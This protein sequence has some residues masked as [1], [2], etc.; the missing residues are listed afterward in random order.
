MPEPLAQ[1]T[2]HMMYGDTPVCL[3]VYRCTLAALPGTPRSSPDKDPLGTHPPRK[4]KTPRGAEQITRECTPSSGHGRRRRSGP[5]PGC[6]DPTQRHKTQATAGFKGLHTALYSLRDSFKLFAKSQPG[7]HMDKVKDPRITESL[8][9]FYL[10]LI[11]PFIF[12]V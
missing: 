5:A 11:H 6:R 1:T 8:T 7:L 3:V 9:L 2:F 12:L 4:A 10:L